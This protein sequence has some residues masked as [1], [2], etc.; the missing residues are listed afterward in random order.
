MRFPLSKQSFIN[1]WHK[2]A[3][4]RLTPHQSYCNFEDCPYFALSKGCNIMANSKKLPQALA[5]ISAEQLIFVRELER[6]LEKVRDE[7]SEELKARVIKTLADKKAL[8]E[9]VNLK[10]M[11]EEVMAEHQ[12]AIDRTALGLPNIDAGSA[13]AYI[14][15]AFGRLG[16]ATNKDAPLSHAQAL[17]KIKE[18]FQEQLTQRLEAA[19]TQRERAQNG[20]KIPS[21]KKIIKQIH[22][23]YEAM[24]LRYFIQLKGYHAAEGLSPEQL[25]YKLAKEKKRLDNEIANKKLEQK[26]LPSL[27]A[28]AKLY[29]FASGFFTGGSIYVLGM[30]LVGLVPALPALVLPLEILVTGISAAMF[31][32]SARINWL[33]IMVEAVSLI[34][35]LFFNPAHAELGFFKKIG[36]WF[37]QSEIS[38]KAL[39]NTAKGSLNTIAAAGIGLLVVSGTV[40][41]LNVF[42][43]WLPLG[44]D[45]AAL[46]MIGAGPVPFFVAGFTLFAVMGLIYFV[47]SNLSLLKID[48]GEF[49]HGEHLQ[50]QETL[51]FIDGTSNLAVHKRFG[52]N[53]SLAV[54]GIA[55]TMA[56][57]YAMLTAMLPAAFVVAGAAVS[58]QF[59]LVPLLVGLVFGLSHFYFTRSHTST[60]RLLT[61]SIGLTG[62]LKTDNDDENTVKVK[63]GLFDRLSAGADVTGLDIPDYQ[64]QASNANAAPTFYS[65]PIKWIWHKFFNT[66]EDNSERARVVNAAGQGGPAVEGAIP[67][68]SGLFGQT[69]GT[70]LGI[71]PGIGAAFGS[72]NANSVGMR[73]LKTKI[74]ELEVLERDRAILEQAATAEVKGTSEYQLGEAA[75]EATIY[76]EGRAR[77]VSR[78]VDHYGVKTSLLP[79]T[80]IYSGESKVEAAKTM[81]EQL[82]AYVADP[83]AVAEPLAFLYQPVRA[84]VQADQGLAGDKRLSPEF[85]PLSEGNLGE[86][87]ARA[88][89]AMRV[90]D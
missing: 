47:I 24:R 59:V 85:N 54:V 30:L 63:D 21:D 44:S 7:K 88:A 17:E 57:V 78:D 18:H 40:S 23:E 33:S 41:L 69:A 52:F 90:A 75:A 11:A 29:S 10:T 80:N 87:A 8:G 81:V 62:K 51:R 13:Q 3:E 43:G 60:E 76:A 64:A 46:S 28:N 20:V 15:N 53:F 9:G 1:F 16:I 45:V 35:K 38:F 25:R 4:Q 32:Y 37:K 34:V 56:G 48:S 22:D 19:K 36:L 66:T 5:A 82:D 71:V 31:Y 6:T 39:F 27:L 67:M 50:T 2:N 73:K 74:T 42:L 65:N 68:F 58:M 84:K 26:L 49:K 14:Q 55:A 83:T 70:Y 61:N 77:Q 89:G 86:I 12:L 79:N 72:Y